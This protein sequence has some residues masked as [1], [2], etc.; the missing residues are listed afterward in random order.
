MHV[1]NVA[2]YL[3]TFLVHFPASVRDAMG[4]PASGGQRLPRALLSLA[5]GVVVYW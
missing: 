3:A 4:V 2:C 1:G 5:P